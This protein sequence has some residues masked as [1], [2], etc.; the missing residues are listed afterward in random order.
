MYIKIIISLLISIFIFSGCEISNLN[1]K[2]NSPQ[3][4]TSDIKQ[5]VGVS[6]DDIEKIYG[7][8]EQAAYYINKNDL[9]NMKSNYIS[10][11]NFN[12]YYIINKLDTYQYLTYALPG[13]SENEIR[14]E[15]DILLFKNILQRKLSEFENNPNLLLKVDY[16]NPGQITRFKRSNDGSESYQ[17]DSI[18][19]DDNDPMSLALQ[20]YDKIKAN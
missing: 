9:K 8:P 17:G 20:E 4:T 1:N 11:R 19:F 13:E 16:D 6:Y 7:S 18:S 2:I 12:Y 5:L 10:L 15:N 14:T 3:M